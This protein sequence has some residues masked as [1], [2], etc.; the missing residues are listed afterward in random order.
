MKTNVFDK[1]GKVKNEI[2]LPKFF[3]SEIRYDIVAKVLNSKKQFQPYSP[4]ILAGKQYSASG[5]IV[6][7]RKVWK[8][9]YGRG[10]SRVPRKILTRRGS[11]FN[12]EGATSPNTRGGRRAHPPLVISRIKKDKINKKELKI[13]F[14]SAIS[15]T[16]KYEELLKKYETLDDKKIKKLPFV[17]SSDLLKLKVKSFLIILRTILEEDLYSIAIKN[18]KIRKGK[19]KLRGRKYKS[20]AGLLLV[21]GNDE[22]FNSKI[23]DSKNVKS[24]SVINL[25]K[26][27][28]GRLTIY[29]EKAIEDLNN[30]FKEKVK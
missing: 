9:Q 30:K 24:L 11:Q 19:G 18:K 22:K 28:L 3:S 6:H 29:T 12:W 14:F 20:N 8:S 7:K 5:K 4:M 10:M 26:G 25:A 17:I 16:G 2:D 13:A 21:I 1:N 15:A 27:G 23:F